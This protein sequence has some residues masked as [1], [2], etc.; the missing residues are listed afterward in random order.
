MKLSDFD[1]E[2]PPEL[3]A[4]H[5]VH[6]R[7]AARLMVLERATG[8]ISHHIFADLPILLRSGDV[9]VVNDTRVIAARLRGRKPTGGAVEI[10][11]LRPVLNPS[12]AS[13]SGP[14]P[15]VPNVNPLDARTWEALVRPGRGVGAGRVLEIA[16]DVN[17]EVLDVRP[18]GVRIVRVQGGRAMREVLGAYGEVPL[19]P[20]VHEPLDRPEDYQ[21][22]Y[23]VQSGAV[24]APTAGLHFTEDLID[25]IGFVG[26]DLV[27]ITMHIGLGTF[28]AVTAD[29]IA[30]HRMDAEWFEVTPS[31]AAAIN[32]S[33]RR[34]GRV[35][36]VGTS[37]VRTLET[38][39]DP[40]GMVRPG[41]GWSTLFIYPGFRFAAT[42]VMITNFH[43]P[44][45]TLLMLVSAF[46]GRDLIARA[47]DDAIAQRYRFYSFG[48]AMLIV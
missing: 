16:P 11:L 19:P 28:R 2:L 7:D 14:A 25:R 20:Y 21:T 26:L 32:E 3:I 17:L 4:Q 37:A 1:Y 6:P 13:G 5:P 44:R 43:L 30:E 45:T 15:D 41:T 35:V 34:G 23:A 33:K 9:V 24:A 22:V 12:S 36:T 31:A 8:S 27:R 29:D 39:A 18:D 42:D 48:D 46:A 47:Y 10:L 38:A 40:D